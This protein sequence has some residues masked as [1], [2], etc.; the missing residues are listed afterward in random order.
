MMTWLAPLET[1]KLI[2][3]GSALPVI[4]EIIIVVD[5]WQLSDYYNRQ[6]EKTYF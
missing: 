2:S 5:L 6:L 3:S 1:K 4:P